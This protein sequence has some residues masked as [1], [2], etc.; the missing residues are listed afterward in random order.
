MQND[1]SD[2]GFEER[3]KILLEATKLVA[4]PNYKQKFMKYLYLAN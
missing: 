1:D 3:K 2:Y 4:A